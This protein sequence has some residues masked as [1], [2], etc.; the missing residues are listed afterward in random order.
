MTLLQLWSEEVDRLRPEARAA[1][2]AGIG[3]F[4]NREAQADL[5]TEERIRRQRAEMPPFPAKEAVDRQ[6]AG[7]RCRVIVPPK[8]SAAPRAVYVHFHGGGMVSGSPETMDIP[9]VGL[10]R[11]FGVAVVSP[12]YRK[13]PE[14]PYPAGPDDA[15]EVAA[16]VLQH[17][18]EEFGTDRV[19]IGGESAGGYL[20]AL[21]ALRLRDRLPALF[22]RV[23]GLN[24]VFGVYDWGRSP[25]QRGMRPHDGPDILSPEGIEFVSECYLPGMTDD[26]RRAPEI[27]PVFADLHDLP[28]LFLSVGTCDHLVDDTLLFATRAAAAGNEVELFVAPEMPHAFFAFPCGVTNLWVDR[29][30]AWLEGVLGNP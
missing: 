14:H 7:V 10:A 24:L 20:T 15:Y 27:S 28:S 9:N 19:V 13:A 17:A 3:M 1:V 12:D 30:R 25:S 11:D 8:P 2:K 21:V 26:E 6:I 16:W 4:A 5:S 29:L 22:D 23:I 18:K